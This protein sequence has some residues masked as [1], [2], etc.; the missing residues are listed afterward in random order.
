VV[1]AV[2]IGGKRSSRAGTK[3]GSTLSYLNGG[4]A[5]NRMSSIWRRDPDG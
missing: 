4:G 1:E 3:D 2:K 5:T